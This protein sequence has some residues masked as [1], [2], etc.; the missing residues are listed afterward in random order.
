M[1]LCRVFHANKHQ[2]LVA[3][4]TRCISGPSVPAS[5]YCYDAYD[6]PKNLVLTALLY[7]SIKK[8]S[9]LDHH[10]TC[11]NGCSFR[12]TPLGVYDLLLPA[13]LLLLLLYAA[14]GYRT[15]ILKNK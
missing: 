13:L 14:L 3:L 10:M 11:K 8:G 5:F 9:E 1:N 15:G 6:R 12:A 4:N 7:V 2:P